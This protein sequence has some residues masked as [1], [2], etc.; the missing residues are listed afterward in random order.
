MSILN[1]YVKS[2]P[3]PQNALDIFK[4]EWVSA[5]PEPL[6]QLK[7][8]TLPLFGHTALN[9]FNE[10][11]GGVRGKSILELGPLEGGH[12]YMLERLGAAEVIAIEANT[13]AFVKCLIAKEVLNLQRVH[14]LCG[15]F[16]EYLRKPGP[17]FEICIASGVLYHM[18]DPAELIAL[19]AKRCSEHIYLWTHYYDPAIISANLIL[20]TKFKGSTK[21]TY[22]GFSHTLYRQEYQ[23][24]LYLPT[25]LGGTASYSQWM[26]RDDILNCLQYFGLRV[27]ATSFD[28]PHHPHGP[29][30][31]LALVKNSVNN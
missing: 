30:F 21:H 18:Q 2:A 3:D 19:I 22:Q 12:S 13:R 11:I 29:A 31:A 9:W 23:S 28:E 6:D 10:E 17:N 16:V 7:A 20:S 26:T 5:F 25:F 27:L 8:G 1:S 4:G 14:F 24:S 15:D